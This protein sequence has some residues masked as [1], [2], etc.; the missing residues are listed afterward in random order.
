MNFDLYEPFLNKGGK[1]CP[2]VKPKR[3]DFTAIWLRMSQQDIASILEHVRAGDKG[4]KMQLP[5]VCWTGRCIGDYR[6]DSDMKPTQFI[7]IDIDHVD[8]P[9]KVFDDFF[10]AHESE[11][12][13]NKLAFAHVTPS[14]KGLRL[15]F[16]A[17]KEIKSLSEYMLHLDDL[18]GFHKIGDFDPSVKNLGR[19]SFLAS[20]D[21]ALFLEHSIMFD[22][23]EVDGEYIIEAGESITTAVK[24][25]KDKNSEPTQPKPTNVASIPFDGGVQAFTEDEKQQFDAFRYR[26]FE[27]K[28]IINKYLEVNGEPGSGERH[29]YFNEMVKN[30]R[31]ITDN[32]KRLL[33][34]Y[35]PEFGHSLEE[36]WSQIISICRVNTLSRLP[37]SF[38]FFL[39]DNGFYEVRN[40]NVGDLKEYMMEE[41]TSVDEGIPYL[42]PI[43]REFLR[44]A[45]KDF[46]V[47]M[48]NAMLPI[49]GTLTS[50]V[51]A[52]YP[53]DNRE[54]STSFFSVI[55]APPGTGKGFV[56]R[57]LDLLFEDLRLRDFVQS[58]RENV[59][60]RVMQRKG[61]NDK[62]PDAP[63]V[64]LRLIPPKNSEA[65]FLQKQRDNKGYHMFTYAAEMDSWAKGVRAAGGNKDDMIRIAW[66]NGEY[67]QQFKS[68]NTFKG[69]VRLYWNVLITGTIQQVEN[70]FKNVENGLVTR[71]SFCSIE[72]QEFAPPPVWKSLSR[73]EVSVVKKF[74][75]R[76]DSNTY[77]SPCTIVPDDL[78]GVNDDDFDKE[79]DWRFKFKEKKT[80]DMSWVMPTINAFHAE[81]MRMAAKDIDRARD[82]F[83]RRVAVRGFRLGMICYCLWEN[84]RQSDLEKCCDFIDW[85]MHKDLENIMNL[86]GAK[87]NEQTDVV[88]HVVQRTVYDALGDK[89]S[90]DDVYVVCVKQG[91][92][93][94]VRR[95][96]H[97]WKKLGYIEVVDK[98]HYVKVKPKRGD[99]KK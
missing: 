49:L 36:R 29:N 4:A 77:E 52:I 97:D 25:R 73:R 46:V 22:N 65:E 62:A 30:F 90:R 48:V 10:K 9:A 87:Y 75:K 32:N 68:F 43:F 60:L 88:Q 40:K 86:W 92:K 61:A 1:W 94:P 17:C 5:A 12:R 26:G 76:C 74:M 27:L 11:L 38:Y 80:I 69:T 84:P 28:T 99:N 51:R 42:P 55:Y 91:I 96:V 81:Q 85:W 98:E 16:L 79:V 15:V 50:Y 83:R 37:K 34:Y 18:F 78:L 3:V 31:C 7:M 8:D 70:Y 47:P 14:G 54:H 6:R 33:L 89:F 53:Y 95:I 35:L 19:L 39:K 41:G 23:Q 21:D 58:E 63:H 56:E 72:N 66:D 82:V 2:G 45:P 71:C 44:C 67:G 57:L 24:S 93:T 64:S 59:Y 13:K 20:Q